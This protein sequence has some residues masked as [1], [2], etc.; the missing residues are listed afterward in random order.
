MNSYDFPLSNKT[1]FVNIRSIEFVDI[2]ANFDIKNELIG[3]ASKKILKSSISNWTR[4]IDLIEN[5]KLSHALKL[6]DMNEQTHIQKFTNKD[7]MIKF[8]ELKTLEDIVTFSKKYGLLGVSAPSKEQL[9]SVDWAVLQTKHPIY[10]YNS[11]GFSVFE[12]LDIWWWH[13]TQVRSILKL[14]RA[15]KSYDS[16]ES[17]INIIE[18]KMRKGR[19]SPI[20]EDQTI[21]ERYFVN[22]ING[23]EIFI[24]PEIIEGSSITDIG[25]YTLTNLLAF[26]ISGGVNIGIDEIVYDSPKAE[27]IFTE[28]RYTSFLLAAI[29]Y[30]LWQTL[31]DE[32]EVSI[33]AYE[34]C[35]IPFVKYGKQIYC[36]SACRQGAYRIRLKRK[37]DN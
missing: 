8:S 29:Y 37:E 27:L 12:P 9:E 3:P 17:V 31:K 2:Q 16:E 7:I 1:E 25:K 15:I 5:K 23:D 19:F 32:K 11:Y 4:A 22:W 36:S 6:T 30:D 35:K 24:L 28:Q 33:C 34:E 21:S 10:V 26:H 18:I 20:E 14:Y 13:I